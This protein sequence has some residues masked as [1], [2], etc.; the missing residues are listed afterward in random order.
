MPAERIAAPVRSG[1]RKGAAKIEHDAGLQRIERR[2]GITATDT[3][4]SR[5]RERIDQE[6]RFGEVDVTCQPCAGEERTTIVT[7]RAS[8]WA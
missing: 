5:R 2:F 6:T 7:R 1:I 3:S 8:P 4:W